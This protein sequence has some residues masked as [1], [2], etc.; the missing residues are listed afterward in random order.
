VAAS[1]AGVRLA[2]TRRVPHGFRTV[3]LAVRQTRAPTHLGRLRWWDS[4]TRA[5]LLAHVSI[6]RYDAHR[7]IEESRRHCQKAVVIEQRIS[8]AS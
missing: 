8:V 1:R 2:L 7:S 3:R 4:A 6:L 5:W